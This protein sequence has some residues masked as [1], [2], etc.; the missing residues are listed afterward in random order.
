MP[1]THSVDLATCKKCHLCAEVCPAGIIQADE[2]ARFLEDRVSLCIRCGQ[3]MAACPTKSITIESLSY[4]KDFFELPQRQEGWQ[5]AFC[6]L[7]SSRR[8][9]RKFQDRPVP[10]ELL[11][12]IVRAI[13]FAPPGFTPLTVELTVVNN[14]ELI[15]SAVPLM[16]EM[17]DRL[18]KMQANP[19]MRPFF[20][21]MVG[22]ETYQVLGEHVLP[23]MKV[24]MPALK[25]GSED[26]IARG[27]PAMILFHAP[28]HNDDVF[29]ALAF[30]LLA[31]HSVGLGACAIGLIPP[32]INRNPK[33]KKMFQIPE[34]NLVL[35]S[36]VLG[37]PKYKYSWGINRSPA[38]LT[39]I[40]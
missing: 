14:R 4:E 23:L 30:G 17:Y 19:F 22:K 26:T 38:G 34:G 35:S 12:K 18:L 40:E 29:I 32:A 24:R 7:I 33:L 39:Y 6:G 28:A 20:K 25:A 21:L 1:A 11:E 27:A 3:C 10:R 36:M 13:T 5:E 2:T 15:R 31:A 8:S 37:Y 9:I 16:V